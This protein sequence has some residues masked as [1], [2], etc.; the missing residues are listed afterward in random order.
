LSGPLVQR[1]QLEMTDQLDRRELME[2]WDLLELQD[3]LE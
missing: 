2:D 1:G 3:R